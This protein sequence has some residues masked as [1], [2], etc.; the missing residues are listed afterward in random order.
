MQPLS[1][2]ELVLA[3]DA[4]VHPAPEGR[5]VTAPGLNAVLRQLAQAATD[6]AGAAPAVVVLASAAALPATGEPATLYIAADTGQLFRWEAAGP[7]YLPLAASPLG[8]ALREALTAAHAP[9]ATNAV[10]TLADVA[11]ADGHDVTGMRLVG[12]TRTRVAYRGQGTAQN[13][14]LDGLWQAL[15]AAQPDD[16]VLQLSRAAIAGLPRA[17]QQVLLPV[18]VSYD[19]GGFD[20]DTLGRADGLTLLGGAGVV[21]GRH[22]TVRHSYQASSG[23]GWPDGAPNV[24]YQVYD[25]HVTSTTTPGNVPSCAVGVAGGRL[26]HTGRLAVAGARGVLAAR[27]PGSQVPIIYDH[28]GPVVASQACVAFELNDQATVCQRGDVVLRDQATAGTL[29]TGAQ[30]ELRRG[31]LDLRAAAP[32]AGFALEAGTTLTLLD[33]T[34]LGGL[35]AQPLAAGQPAGATVHLYGSTTLTASDFAPELTV[36]DHRPVAPAAGLSAPPAPA[37]LT[38]PDLVTERR[39]DF[40]VAPDRTFAAYEFTFDGGT[41]WQPATAAALPLPLGAVP[42]RTYGVRVAP[43]ALGQPASAPAYA[44]AQPAARYVP[45]LRARYYSGFAG[46]DRNFERFETQTP[47]FEEIVVSAGRFRDPVFDNYGRV[48]NSLDYFTVLYDTWLWITE[49]GTYS[50]GSRADDASAMWLDDDVQHPTTANRLEDRGGVYL[51]AGP[52]RLRLAFSEQAGAQTADYYWYGPGVSDILNAG[53]LRL[54]TTQPLVPDAGRAPAGLL[55]DP[56]FDLPMGT[57]WVA[58]RGWDVVDGVLLGT[59]SDFTSTSFSLPTA[60]VSDA[61]E[62]EIS[63]ELAPNAQLNV[64]FN[65]MTPTSTIL[66]TSGVHRLPLAATT[67]APQLLLRAEA[68]SLVRVHYVQVRHVAAATAT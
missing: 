47:L 27:A 68:S 23:L 6:P 56:D 64:S 17:A 7:A 25:L 31:V 67:E 58:T 61:Y 40:I 57:A 32:T 44:P 52:H 65:N 45:G 49:A 37:P 53:R 29:R 66:T 24:D 28:E 50:F 12:S 54:L 59:D 48:A 8:T 18:G 30:L 15:A 62:L 22:A 63:L 9:S 19:T 42:A 26:L 39:A 1:F 33:V 55:A 5:K 36:V 3:I 34:V 2:D 43:T 60:Q 20:I 10:A 16:T 46:F 35:P 4:A 21:Q 11:A 38:V 13:P 14:G 51:A 41:T